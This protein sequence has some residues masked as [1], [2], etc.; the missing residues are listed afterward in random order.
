[1]TTSHVEEAFPVPEKQLKARKRVFILQNRRKIDGNMAVMK[2]L[3][4]AGAAGS[5]VCESEGR[6]SASSC[7]T[8]LFNAIS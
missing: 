3:T 6:L 1:M 2:L 4:R 7:S 8:V 5:N